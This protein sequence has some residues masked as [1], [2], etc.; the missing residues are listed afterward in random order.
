MQKPKTPSALVRSPTS[1]KRPMISDSATAETIAP[2]TPCTARAP[3]S[4]PWVVDTPHAT[5]AAVKIAIPVRNSFRW[6]NRSPS[7]PPRSRNPPNVSRYAFT[8]QA[9][10]VSVNPRSSR[11]EGSATFTIVMS[12]TII[13]SPRHRTYRASQRERVSAMFMS[14]SSSLLSEG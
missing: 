12:T 4:S 5:D 8:T 11:I 3:I 13:R 2:P 10:D 9:R 1:V 6:P 7:R 14:A